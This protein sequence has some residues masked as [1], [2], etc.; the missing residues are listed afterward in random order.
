MSSER[1]QP[2]QPRIPLHLSMDD[3]EPMYR[4]IES[5]LRTSSSPASSSRNEASLHAGFSQRPLVQ[6]HHDTRAYEDLEG[7]GFIRTRQGMGTVVAEIPDE[8]MAAYRREAVD[9]AMGEAVRAGR[10]A[11]LTDDELRDILEETLQREVANVH[12]GGT[13]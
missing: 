13:P 3:P 9:G 11:G 5:Q 6:R 7:E 2:T 8:K 4:Q 12:H 1:S 10:R